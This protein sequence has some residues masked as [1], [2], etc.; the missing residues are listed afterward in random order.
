MFLCHSCRPLWLL[1]LSDYKNQ[2]EKNIEIL[3]KIQHDGDLLETAFCILASLKGFEVTNP[4]GRM[5]ELVPVEEM[6]KQVKD[7]Y[8]VRNLQGDTCSIS[9]EEMN[10]L[11]NDVCDY[12]EYRLNR[13]IR[14]G[15]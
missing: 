11:Q 4:I 7:G 15:R 10:H 14:K 2:K 3:N 5:S 12:I 1:G 8:Y 9:V 13:W 6:M